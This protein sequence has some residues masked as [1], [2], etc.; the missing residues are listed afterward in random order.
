MDIVDISVLYYFSRLITR[1]KISHRKLTTT[2]LSL[3]RTPEFPLQ[4][5]VNSGHYTS[6]HAELATV[7]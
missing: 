1:K 4:T 6:L 7:E 5:A 3:F 2:A